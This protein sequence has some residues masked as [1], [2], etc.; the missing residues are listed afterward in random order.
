MHAETALRQSENNLIESG[1]R[2]G[3]V[4]IFQCEKNPEHFH[5]YFKPSKKS[6]ISGFAEMV[7]IGL[8]D[9]L[10]TAVTIA[11]IGYGADDSKWKPIVQNDNMPSDILETLFESNQ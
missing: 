1:V 9:D 8:Y 4:I 7:K 10:D 5:L 6:E 11:C 3:S 2:N